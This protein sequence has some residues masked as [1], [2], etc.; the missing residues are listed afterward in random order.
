MITN[1]K[2][3]KWLDD[4]PPP[5]V[6][7]VGCLVAILGLS[8]MVEILMWSIYVVSLLAPPFQSLQPPK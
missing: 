2:L 8:V 6:I 1:A 4:T 7:F 3:D 5:I